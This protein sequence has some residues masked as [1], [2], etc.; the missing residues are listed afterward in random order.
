MKKWIRQEMKDWKA[1]PERTR[2][3]VFSLF[4]VLF[5]GVLLCVIPLA[6]MMMG[7]L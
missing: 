7:V 5:Y 4:F 3:G 1:L 2:L 6:L